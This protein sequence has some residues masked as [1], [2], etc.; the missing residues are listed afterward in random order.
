M[1]IIHRAGKVHSNFDPVS[2]LWRHVP[3]TDGP[4][5]DHTKSVNLSESIED[6]LKDMFTELGS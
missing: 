2:W 5:M 1:E 4:V 3:I 6:P